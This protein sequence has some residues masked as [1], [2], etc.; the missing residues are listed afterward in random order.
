MRIRESWLSVQAVAVTVAESPERVAFR[1]TGFAAPW[2][3]A[4]QMM[5]LS[6]ATTLTVLTIAWR[7]ASL[8]IKYGIS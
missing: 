5:M 7:G 8:I 4:V 6:L 2:V 3:L 1:D